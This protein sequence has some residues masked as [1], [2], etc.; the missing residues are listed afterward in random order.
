MS[1]HSAISA[2]H[3]HGFDVSTAVLRSA[4]WTASYLRQAG[5]IDGICGLAA[6]LLAYRVRFDGAAGH[7]VAYLL[8]SLALPCAWL[9]TVA[10]A[11]GYDSRFIGVGPDEFRKVLHAGVFLTAAVAIFSYAIKADLARGYVVI[12]LPSVTLFDLIARYALRKH[13]HRVRR[14]GDC[15]RKVVVVGYAPVVD[16]ITT[17]LRRETYHGLTV[18][19]ACVAGAT[20]AGVIADVPAV[21]GL[22]EV[23]DV[24]RRFDADTVAVLACP[25][26]AGDRLRKLAWDLEKTG[27]DLCVAPA[28]LDVAG[29][30]TTIRP[31]AGLPLL[32]MDHP[33]F[34]GARLVMKS[35]FDKLLALAGLIFASPLLGLLALIIRL[36]DGGP[37]LFRQTRVG[38]DGRMFSVY[39]L[40]TMVTDAESRKA[41]LADSNQ[42]QGPLFKIRNDPRIT[43]AGSWLRRWSLD[44][45]PQLV[46]VLTGDMALVGPRPALP[47]EA[48]MYGDHVRRRLAVKPGITGLWQVNGRSDLSWDEAVRLD[49]RYVENWSFMLDL[50][51]LWK[52][53]AAVVRGSGA[54]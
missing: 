46:N 12:A 39:K 8:A 22:D 13:L 7:P 54:Y 1:G 10:L 5:V 3:R 2:A 52:T 42:H 36:D 51:I 40:R 4:S 9:A 21:G 23:A 19:A 33:E 35:A 43:R 27:T 28:L 30:R 17:M 34:S 47:E 49:L 26:M 11:G 45:L 15:M 18:V 44:E 32:H 37:V 16:D 48:A 38:K 41:D 20:E 29:P 6:G 25:E 50:Q 14:Q 53:C 31:V 24:V